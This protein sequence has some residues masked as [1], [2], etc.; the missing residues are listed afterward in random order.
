MQVEV[1]KAWEMYFDGATRS[2]NGQKQ[3]N[4]KNNK[5]GIGVVF[6]TPNNAIIPHSFVLTEGCSN[7]EAE[8]EAVIAGLELALQIPIE[9]LL[10]Y[11]DSELV[12]KQLRGEYIVKKASLTP[13]HERASQ[14]LSQFRKVNIFHVKRRIN[15][16][17]DSLAS[18]AAS[19]SL[20]DRETIIVTVGERRVL[21]PLT[22]IS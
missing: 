10:V 2:P 14:L 8:Y 18:L 1:Q 17:A 21:Q 13:Y 4:L 20:P 7:N 19:L 6:V 12:I 3:E 11:G 9:E 16:Q 22:E 15:A 5:S